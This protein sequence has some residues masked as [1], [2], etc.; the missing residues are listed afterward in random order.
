MRKTVSTVGRSLRFISA[1]ANSYSKS[2]TARMPRTMQSARSRATR[3]ITRPSNDTMRKVA[4]SPR[5]AV[6]SSIISSRSSTVNSAVLEGLAPTAT[7]TSSKICR[8]R[9]MTSRWP[10]CSGSNIP[11]YTARLARASLL[12]GEMRTPHRSRRFASMSRQRRS[13]GRRGAVERERGLAEAARAE[14]EERADAL[15]RH[16]LGEVLGDHPPVGEQQPAAAERLQR[17]LHQAGVI[18]RVEEHDVEAVAGAVERFQLTQHVGA[19]HAGGVGHAERRHVVAERGHRP[20]V[21][22]DERGLGR[23]ARERLQPT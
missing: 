16:A 10:L 7:I 11:V 5:L 8:L 18:G 20:R 23:A 1:M 15:G 19:P 21:A 14:R 3:S 12:D 22:L 17:G 6:A 13:G 9:W 4:P 2:D